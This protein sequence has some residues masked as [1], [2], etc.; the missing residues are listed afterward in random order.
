MQGSGKAFVSV[1]W[2][3]GSLCGPL[4]ARYSIYLLYW[5]K[6]ANTNAKSAASWTTSSRRAYIHSRPRRHHLRRANCNG[7]APR[8]T[9][10]QVLNLLA[11][12]VQK[13]KCNLLALLVQKYIYE[14]LPQRHALNT[15]L[16]TGTN[17]Q[18]LIL[19]ALLVQKY[20]FFSS[21]RSATLSTHT[22][23]R[24][25]PHARRPAGGGDIS[26]GQCWLG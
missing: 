1:A 21:C 12:L 10:T 2:S 20:K 19:L 11:S 8:S 16:L 4:G 17:V 26:S 24:T 7:T 13:Y 25:H 23:P 22:Q 18:I 9:H 3:R 5:Y 14:E 6:S 15:H